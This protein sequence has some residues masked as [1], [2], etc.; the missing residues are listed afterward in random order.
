MNYELGVISSF[1][2]LNRVYKL[3]E[4]NSQLLITMDCFAALRND[5]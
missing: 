4:A 1:S 3:G 5:V 2:I